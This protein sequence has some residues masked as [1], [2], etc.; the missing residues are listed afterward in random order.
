[1]IEVIFETHSTSLDNEN[2]LALGHWDAPLSGL[3]KRQAA[4]LGRRH[5]PGAVTEVFCSDLQRSYRTAEIAF[6][7]RKDVAIRKDPRLRECDY[8]SWTRAALA[9]V[10]ASR[11]DR[12]VVRK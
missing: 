6:R 4:E 11:A 3:G 5:E 7:G 2:G 9:R 8:G 12:V 10:A 1:M